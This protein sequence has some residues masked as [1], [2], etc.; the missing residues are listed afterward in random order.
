MHTREVCDRPKK[1]LGSGR[2]GG[3]LGARRRPGPG[4]RDRGDRLGDLVLDLA[5]ER[6][7]AAADVADED[8]E[9]EGR[10]FVHR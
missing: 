3:A 5:G 1:L 2:G 10:G 7:L 8:R 4:G 9:G 6:R